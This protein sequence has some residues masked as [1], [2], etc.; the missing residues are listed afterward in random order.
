MVTEV[1]ELRIEPLCFLQTNNVDGRFFPFNATNTNAFES[2]TIKQ[3]W[4]SELFQNTTLFYSIVILFLL[5][6]FFL[7]DRQIN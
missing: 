7:L 2:L 5:F 1:V 3:L 6:F 4:Y